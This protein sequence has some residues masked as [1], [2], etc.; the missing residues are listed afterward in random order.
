MS[1]NKR[2]SQTDLIDV[3][4]QSCP[5]INKTDVK[6]V[7][8]NTLSTISDLLVANECDIRLPG[9]G[10]VKTGKAKGRVAKDWNGNEHFIKPR[11]TISLQLSSSLKKRLKGE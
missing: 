1:D 3:V 11:K 6:K 10:I 2:I 8:L 9:L 7:V 4:Y 5:G